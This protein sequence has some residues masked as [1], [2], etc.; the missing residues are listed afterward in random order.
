LEKTF[1]FIV[2]RGD[3]IE[4]GRLPRTVSAYQA[5]DLTLFDGKVQVAQNLPAAEMFR[6][7]S[8]LNH[9]SGD[10]FRR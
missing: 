8:R 5:Q 9:S 4:E 1:I 10:K 6:Y 7:V 3:D 2:K